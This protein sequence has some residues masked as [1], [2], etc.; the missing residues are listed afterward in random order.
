[1]KKIILLLLISQM[2]FSSCNQGRKQN[3]ISISGAW[4]LYPLAVR[5]AEEYNKLNPEIRIDISAGGAGKG[6]A[7]VLGGL[8][9]IGMVSRS[10]YP[11]EIAKGALPFAV[12]KD[13]VVAVVSDKNPV[14]Q[15]LHAKGLTKDD[16]RKMWITE[17][18]K[19]W[20]DIAGNGSDIPLHVYTRSDA[21]GAAE[22]WAMYLGGRQ[23]DLGGVGVYGDPGLAMAVQQDPNGIGFNNIGYAYDFNTKLPVTGLS[24]VPIDLDGSGLIEDRESFYQSVGSVTSAISSGRYPSPPSRELY[25]VISDKCLN[26]KVLT[27]FLKWVLAD[28]QKYAGEAGYVPF[29]GG[30]SEKTLHKAEQD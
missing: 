1:M 6:M 22:I 8:V 30:S 7:D 24:I 20:G 14:L 28:G 18:Y 21:C 11:E 25:F 12:A 5:W 26:N 29:A 9:E 2:I 19:T 13:A 10:I 23:E 17:Q 16:F 15:E 4:A 3:T 27:D